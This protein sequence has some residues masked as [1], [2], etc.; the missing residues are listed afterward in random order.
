[1]TSGYTPESMARKIAGWKAARARAHAGE[2]FI[3]VAQI[4]GSDM[5]KIGFS[6]DPAK[7]MKGIWCYRWGT[8]ARL[9]AQIP[10]TWA[11]EKALHRALDDGSIYHTGEY[12]PSAVLFHDAIPTELRAAVADR[13][14]A[15]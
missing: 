13:Q 5:V 1:M 12:Y 15:P 11:Q 3:Y 14:A 7:R 10:A 8:K 9:L 4:V 2:G 6:L